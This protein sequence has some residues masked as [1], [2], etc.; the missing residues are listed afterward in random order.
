MRARMPEILQHVHVSW[1]G[2]LLTLGILVA[3]LFVRRLLPADRRGRGRAALAFLALS[4]VLRLA[5]GG[6]QSI[7]QDKAASV[8]V[9]L[10]VL[11][12]AF[13]ITGFVALLVFDIG[14]ARVRLSVP[15]LVRDII[16]GV[17]LVVITIGVLQ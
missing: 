4:L 14:F 12:E 1:D 7:D 6:L 11:L 3:L 16:Q 17:V 5:A 2:F 13:G 9:F 10:S 8:V 15:S